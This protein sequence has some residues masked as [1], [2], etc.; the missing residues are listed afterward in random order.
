MKE[1]GVAATLLIKLLYT[2]KSPSRKVSVSTI[3]ILTSQLM[4]VHKR[5]QECVQVCAGVCVC[6][7]VCV[8]HL[9]NRQLTESLIKC[10][11]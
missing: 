4:R 3:G 11:L 1:G 5:R 10:L 7:G 9:G 2:V 8:C 6:T